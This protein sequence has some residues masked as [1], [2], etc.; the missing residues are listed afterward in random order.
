[1]PAFRDGKR[2]YGTWAAKNLWVTQ[3]YADRSKLRSSRYDLG[4]IVLKKRLG[5]RIEPLPVRLYP[6]RF[7]R[8]ELFGYPAGAMRGRELRVCSSPTWAGDGYSRRIPGPVGMAARCN[9][10]GGSN[11]GPWISEYQGGD[12]Y[13]DGVISTGNPSRNTMTTSHFDRA[14]RTLLNDAENR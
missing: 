14:M 11:G 4:M 9:M 3:A 5:Q 8:T 6:D 2:P 7:G 1:M 13:L 12:S 10:A